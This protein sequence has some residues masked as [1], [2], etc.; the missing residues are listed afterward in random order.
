MQDAEFEEKDFEAALYHQLA[1][2]SPNVWSPGQVFEHHFGID[3]AI[4][5]RHLFFMRS[6]NRS[7]FSRKLILNSLNWGYVWQSYGRKRGLPTFEVN[8]LIQA[9]RPQH[10]L[11]QNRSIAKHGIA[12]HY[13]RF[14]SVPHQ[15]S[16]LERLSKKVGNRAVVSY[17]SPACHLWDDLDRFI[18]TD[19]LPDNCSYVTAERMAGHKHWCYQQPGGVG[20]ACSE[21][22][23]ISDISLP[24]R[25]AQLSEN[26]RNLD[27]DPDSA[28]QSLMYLSK[29]V[30]SAVEEELEAGSGM[31][32][33]IQRRFEQIPVNDSQPEARSFFQ[34]AIFSEITNVFW[35]VVGSQSQSAEA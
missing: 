9:K 28:R 8:A 12:G 27:S 21:P 3:A 20:V 26:S 19:K 1:K 13:W 6:L 34:V 16:L 29:N 4:Y 11:G 25:L 30:V 23:P 5:T 33:A 14:E 35:L 2:D 32:R 22:E 7:Y 18:G 24:R 31:A 17:A 15:Q 10:L